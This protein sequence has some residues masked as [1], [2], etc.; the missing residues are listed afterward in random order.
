MVYK[1]IKNI[2][3][4]SVV[5]NPNVFQLLIYDLVVSLEAHSKRYIMIY[6]CC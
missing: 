5:V 6:Y 2:T 4:W 3:L 1:Y